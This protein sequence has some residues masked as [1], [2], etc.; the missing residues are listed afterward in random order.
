MSKEFVDN[1]K[2][3]NAYENKINELNE[4]LNGLRKN[5]QLMEEL[6][7]KYIQ[8]NRLDKTKINIGEYYLYSNTVN[9]LP[10]YSKLIVETALRSL[11]TN[12]NTIKTI[13]TTIEKTRE[14]HRKK[15]T[16]IKKKKNKVENKVE[17]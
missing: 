5:K 2:I 14:N 17:K 11:F 7:I 12:E 13:L 16:S 1:V 9:Q 6:L 3:W 10:V 15:V 8:E 4:Q